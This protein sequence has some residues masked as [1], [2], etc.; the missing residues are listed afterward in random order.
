MNTTLACL[1]A[2]VTPEAQEL[3]KKFK[4]ISTQAVA[5]EGSQFRHARNSAVYKNVYTQL[6]ARGL[7]RHL[8]QNKDIYPRVR[9]NLSFFE[10]VAPVSIAECRIFLWHEHSFFIGWDGLL[11]LQ[12]ACGRHFPDAAWVLA[13]QSGHHLLVPADSD[14]EYTLALQ[15]AEHQWNN[16]L[17]NT[18]VGM[19][20]PGMC[21]IHFAN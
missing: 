15:H 18:N 17:M 10:I 14:K 8:V 4:R 2:R 19:L 20:H 1:Y 6:C 7:E 21:I 11:V 12:Y 13:P 5:V 9:Y 16:M 3:A